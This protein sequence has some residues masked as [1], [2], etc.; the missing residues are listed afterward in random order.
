L[1]AAAFMVAATAVVGGT[2]RV[3]PAET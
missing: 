1:V 2:R 3:N